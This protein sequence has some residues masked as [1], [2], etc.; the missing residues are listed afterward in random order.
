MRFRRQ[1]RGQNAAFVPDFCAKKADKSG[2]CRLNCGR[3]DGRHSGRYFPE[4]PHRAR[5]SLPLDHT[6]R[7]GRPHL[8][9][10]ACAPMHENADGNQ[11]HELHQQRHL[12]PRVPNGQHHN[13]AKERCQYP[14]APR[15]SGQ[16]DPKSVVPCP[17]PEQSHRQKAPASTASLP[18]VVAMGAEMFPQHDQKHRGH[19]DRIDSRQDRGQPPQHRRP[20]AKEQQVDQVLR[21][22]ER[23][24]VAFSVYVHPPSRIS[25]SRSALRHLCCPTRDTAFASLSRQA[26]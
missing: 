13:P 25:S 5:P 26:R 16:P 6:R 14:N 21:Y 10:G 9:R 23:K 18:V 24:R 22:H 20:D 3:S 7:T 4:L 19:K 17:L 12:G 2:F 1:D 8:A 11:E 15:D